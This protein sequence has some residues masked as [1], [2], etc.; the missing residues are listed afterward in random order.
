MGQRGSELAH[1]LLNPHARQCYWR[2]LLQL[3]A[4]RLQQ[5]PSLADWP[6]AQ[7]ARCKDESYAVR[8][9][10]EG[11]IRWG[12]RKEARIDWSRVSDEWK[13]LDTASLHRVVAKVERH[14]RSSSPPSGGFKSDVERRSPSWSEKD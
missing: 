13:A 9:D 1:R 4:A 5:P 7:R 3:Y 2:A 6:K 8:G 14:L 12:P 11:W 10:C